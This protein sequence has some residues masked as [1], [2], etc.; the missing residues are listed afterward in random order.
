MFMRLQIVDP[1]V[2]VSS[3]ELKSCV[4]DGCENRASMSEE[5]LG[6]TYQTL[7]FVLTLLDSVMNDGP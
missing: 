6:G 1:E 2:G 5:T 4:L 7:V 3:D